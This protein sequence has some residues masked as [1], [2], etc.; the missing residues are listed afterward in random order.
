MSPEQTAKVSFFVISDTHALQPDPDTIFRSPFP[1]C[2]VLVHA[3]DLS[4]EGTLV[5]YEQTLNWI[6]AFEAE[7][8]IVIPGNHDVTLDRSY[9][10]KDDCVLTV[11]AH[12]LWTN[13]A[14]R[15]AN[16]IF[17]KETTRTF[18]LSGGAQFKVHTS[19]YQPE[20]HNLAFNYPHFEDRYNPKPTSPTETAV[21]GVAPIPEGI[22]ILI[23]HGPPEE[24]NDFAKL[25]TKDNVGCEWLLK[26]LKRVKPRAHFFGH[27]HEGFGATRVRWEEDGEMTKTI[28]EPPSINELREI[29]SRREDP[30]GDPGNIRCGGVLI[31][32]E[33]PVV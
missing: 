6:K 8:K 5:E 22:D 29:A 20:F 2:D 12:E 10:N 23:T 25:T 31:D 18:T 32:M 21:P 1:T 16:I 13:S 7:L 15:D 19:P 27:I 17:L 26:A 14:A 11:A 9:D 28:L 4:N 24:I 3:G 30:T 33:L